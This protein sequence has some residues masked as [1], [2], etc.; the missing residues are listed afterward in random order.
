MQTGTCCR[1][2]FGLDMPL[3]RQVTGGLQC[4]GPSLALPCLASPRLHL[5][6][7]K[8]TGSYLQ[9]PDS[10]A[11][12]GRPHPPTRLPQAAKLKCP[13]PPRPETGCFVSAEMQ[14]WGV[15]GLTGVGRRGALPF[16]HGLSCYQNYR[17]TRTDTS[18]CFLP[19][20]P[21]GRE[22]RHP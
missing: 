22:I 1:G 13:P 14:V 15:S 4:V 10:A 2:A 3:C 19:F 9:L 12:D 8:A 6:Q 7:P 16:S 18:S 11:E 17:H 5:P 21:S 20:P